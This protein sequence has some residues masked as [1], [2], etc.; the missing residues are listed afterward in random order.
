VQVKK[1]H[2]TGLI[3]TIFIKNLIEK[4]IGI[5]KNVYFCTRFPARATPDDAKKHLYWSN[6]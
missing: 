6:L 4:G 3:S 1:H 2:L 5:E